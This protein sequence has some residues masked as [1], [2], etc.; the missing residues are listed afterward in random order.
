MDQNNSSPRQTDPI[1]LEPEIIE[2]SNSG[3]NSQWRGQ[4][5]SYRAYYFNPAG[6]TSFWT[7]NVYSGGCLSPAI[8]FGFFMLALI[9]YGLLAAI[10]FMFFY[11]VGSVIGTVYQARKLV[12]GILTNPWGWRFWNWGISF[13]LTVWHLSVI[14]AA[15]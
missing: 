5:G 2:P 9:Q 4:R 7:G 8:T 12:E 10:G 11:I 6:A 13:L 3:Q 1:I 14:K 15:C